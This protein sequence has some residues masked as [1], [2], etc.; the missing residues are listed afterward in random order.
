MERAGPSHEAVVLVRSVVDRRASRGGSLAPGAVPFDGTWFLEHSS[1]AK[2]G[3]WLRQQHAT[4]RFDAATILRALPDAPTLAVEAAKA[5]PKTAAGVS[6]IVSSEQ[7]S[8][9]AVVCL[10]ITALGGVEAA[11]QW[12]EASGATRRDRATKTLLAA[13]GRSGENL[14]ALAR[15]VDGV[16]MRPEQASVDAWEKCVAPLLM[17]L[18][19][20]EHRDPLP[21]QETHGGVSAEEFDETITQAALS[22]RDPRKRD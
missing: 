22:D 17:A 20:P 21:P 16:V 12:I 6:V 13:V 11:L 1:P 5:R 15:L 9:S 3:E 2:L 8:A 4:G 19:D 7:R 10:D 14:S 18:L